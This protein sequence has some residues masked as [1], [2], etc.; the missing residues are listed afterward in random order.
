MDSVWSKFKKFVQDRLLGRRLCGG[1]FGYINGAIQ[2]VGK[3]AAHVANRL[4]RARRRECRSKHLVVLYCG[5]T[6]INLMFPS[7]LKI[8][9]YWYFSSNVH[10]RHYS[11]QHRVVK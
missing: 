6:A 11:S 8:Y 4:S 10:V 5:H 3:V 2:S 7:Y 1:W 9:R